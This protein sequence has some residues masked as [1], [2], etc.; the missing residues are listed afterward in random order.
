MQRFVRQARAFVGEDDFEMLETSLVFM[1]LGL[2]KE[3]ETLLSAMCVQAVPGDERSPLPLYYLAYFASLQAESAQAK[4][5]LK[6]AVS[7]N[8]D[9]VFPSRPEAVEIL[10]YAIRTNPEDAFA[11]LHLGNLYAN[12]G[13]VDEAVRCW[14]QAGDLN[15]S[16]SIAFRNLGLH[17]WAKENDL[18][19]AEGFYRKAIA[20]RP[21][22]QTLYRDLADVLMAAERRPEA[23]EVLES[24]PSEGLKRADIIIML[25]QAYYDEQRYT[26]AI[27][28]LESTPYFVNWEGQTVTW[29]IFHK[30]HVQRGEKRFE[31]KDYAGALHDFE[32]ALTYPENIGVGRSNKPREARAQYW[33]GKALEALG[34]PEEARAAWKEGAAGHEHSGEQNRYRELCQKAL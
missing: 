14:K 7:Q 29:N 31:E 18:E 11:R 6:Q 2:V 23:I 26:E 8:K 21:S 15:S 9:F 28:L 22:D 12:L 4:A 5:Y 27:D 32:A 16:L 25:A 13:R 1:E 34:R 10:K 33:R 3:A 30:A 24:T 17:A 19:K 20:A